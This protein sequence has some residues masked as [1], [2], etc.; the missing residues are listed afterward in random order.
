M[1]ILT[2]HLFNLLILGNLLILIQ[3]TSTASAMTLNNYLLS[4][5]NFQEKQHSDGHIKIDIPKEKI[6]QKPNKKKSSKNAIDFY[7]DLRKKTKSFTQNKPKTKQKE[8]YNEP[9]S[10]TGQRILAEE[11]LWSD[12]STWGGKKPSESDDIVEIKSDIKVKLDVSTPVLNHLRIYG[13][14]TFDDTKKNLTLEARI[15]EIMEGGKLTIG[16]SRS[17]PHKNKVNIILHPS[18]GE[19]PKVHVADWFG[20]V[21][22]AIINRGQ[23]IIYGKYRG[24]SEEIVEA[25]KSSKEITLENISKS[26]E[27]G[28]ELVI[29]SSST[30]ANEFEK[31]TI[32]SIPKLEKT[33]T[34]KEELSYYHHLSKSFKINPEFSTGIYGTASNLTRNIVIEGTS[35]EDQLGCVIIHLAD[36]KKKG[37]LIW[38]V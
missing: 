31:V 33:I 14:L 21:S 6:I 29:T 28:D 7:N 10:L 36:P 8:E 18:V 27:I 26:W 3:K 30:K 12:P 32:A 2:R 9:P 20:E 37:T 1:N 25:N 15:I 34:L 16:S 13:E 5:H 35:D 17:I 11:K 38:K 19:T 24:N 4:Q 23:F 22:K